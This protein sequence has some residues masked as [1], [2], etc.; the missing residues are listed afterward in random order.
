MRSS[1]AGGKIAQQF[2]IRKRDFLV[3]EKFHLEEMMQALG[4][5]IGKIQ[6]EESAIEE[7]L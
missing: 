2:S 5:K 4:S 1:I 3:N 6:Q 7:T